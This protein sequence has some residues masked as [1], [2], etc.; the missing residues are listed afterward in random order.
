M[1]AVDASDLDLETVSNSLEFI[2]LSTKLGEG[3]VDG[4]SECCSKVSWAR[5]D[6]AELVVVSKLSHALNVGG[7]LRQSCEDGSD[8]GTLLHGNNSQL[9][10]LIDPDKESLLVVVEDASAFWPVSVEVASVQEPVPLFEEEVIVDQLLLLSCSHG[11]EG[12]EGAS[13]LTC[14]SVAGLDYFLLNL[15]PLLSRD[16]WAKREFSQVATNSD[17]SRLD[18]GGVL[19]REGWAL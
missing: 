10:L 7:S 2:L 14:E 1:L 17:A 8:V 9:I 6:I 12:V 19:G 13:K 16:C 15:I 18:H 5:G 4:G 11:A 3:N